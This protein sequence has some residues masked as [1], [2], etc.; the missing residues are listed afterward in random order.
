[1]AQNAHALGP[2]AALDV[3][4]FLL[5][6]AHEAGMRQIERNGDPGRVVRTEPFA[7]DPGMRP[8]TDAALRELLVQVVEAVLEPGALDRQP[9]V[10]KAEL[11]QLLVRQ[12]RPGEFFTRHCRSWDGIRACPRLAG[13]MNEM[14][15]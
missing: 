14:G 2:G 15:V 9:E 8:H 11:E 10:A 4:D 5:L 6:E 13:M 3:D 1:M 12:R 7:R